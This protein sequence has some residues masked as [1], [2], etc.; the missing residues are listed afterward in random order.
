MVEISYGKYAGRTGVL[1]YNPVTGK[2]LIVLFDDKTSKWITIP[3]EVGYRYLF[4][5]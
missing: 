2:E 3:S 5:N 1:E 4:K